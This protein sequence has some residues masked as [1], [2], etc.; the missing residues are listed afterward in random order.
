MTTPL[1]E[2]G[3]RRAAA[4]LAGAHALAAGAAF[5]ILARDYF[6]DAWGFD[7]AA[8]GAWS[9]L[10]QGL[11][12]WFGAGGPVAW[13]FFVELL[14][15]AVLAPLTV[16]LAWR[17]THRWLA[18]GYIRIY[19][20]IAVFAG[21]ILR[22]VPS[23]ARR[24]FRRRRL[25]EI[26]S[27]RETVRRR[28]AALEGAS[29]PSAD[30]EASTNIPDGARTAAAE[31]LVIDGPSGQEIAP[32]PPDGTPQD[33]TP[34]GPAGEAPRKAGGLVFESSADDMPEND[35]DQA[36][37][38]SPE[39]GGDEAGQGAPPRP[40][41]GLVFDDAAAH[42][43][44]LFSDVRAAVIRWLGS[45]GWVV[46]PDIMVNADAGLGGE[47]YSDI[48]DDNPIGEVPIVAIDGSQ[49][50]L[51]FPH[52]I[53]GAVW[54]AAAWDPDRRSLPSWRGTDA[55]GEPDP[56][57]TIPCPIATAIRAQLRF[58][59]QHAAMLQGVGRYFPQSISSAVLLIGDEPA[60]LDDVSG[61]WDLSGIDILIID[62]PAD[63]DMLGEIFGS[64][65]DDTPPEDEV[66][67]S[68]KQGSLAVRKLQAEGLAA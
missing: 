21:P 25:T 66:I 32:I 52:D 63:A 10:V 34:Q 49:V 46:M 3:K 47:P 56:L 67:L 42:T 23:L 22:A 28:M 62:D 16:V 45:H 24:L 20:L 30:P 54:Q 61:S 59:T 31:P 9:A 55:H 1:P 60:N 35:P 29:D 40:P 5:G 13:S 65:A 43:P 44:S 17:V 68:I 7:L 19:R 26:D 36:K 27:D 58:T 8:G 14:L 57:V 38:V 41:G 37:E 39:A 64:G 53:T 4:F 51:I 11:Q 33:G 6:I 18:A 15:A 48:F 12:R 2:D 50:V